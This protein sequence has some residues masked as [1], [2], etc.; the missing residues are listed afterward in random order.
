MD[1]FLEAFEMACE[2][3]RVDP[4][5]R[6]RGPVAF[7]EV[8]V[9]FT[10]GEWALLDPAQR[11]LYRDVMQENY[12]NV[13]S[14]A[15]ALFILY[16]VSYSNVLFSDLTLCISIRKEKAISLSSNMTYEGRLKELAMFSFEERVRENEE[17]NPRQ[18]DAE[19]VEAHGALLRRSKGNVSSP[20]ELGKAG[21]SYHRPE[22]EQGNHSEEKVDEPINYQGTH[23]DLKET[24]SQEKILREKRKNTCIECGKNFN[25]HSALI[26]HEI[27]HIKERAYEC[28]ECEKS[29]NHTSALIRHQRI[30]RG[31]RPYEYCECGK[32]F[33]HSSVLSTHQLIHTGER[34]YECSE[35][36]KSFIDIASLISHQKVHTGE[37]PYE[38]CECAESFNHNSA[39]IRHQRIPTGERSYKCCKCG[40]SFTQSS[41]LTMH[42]RIH[43][44]LR[45][46]ECS[47]CR[48]SFTDIFLISHQKVHTGQRPYECLSVGKAS[49]RTQA[50]SIIT[51]S[52]KDI[53]SITTFSRAVSGFFFLN[54]FGSSQVVTVK[55]VCIICTL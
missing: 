37:K 48:K 9:Y 8:A 35:C 2:M 32:S 47:E 44:R 39:L 42:Q 54:S 5:D 4:A 38:C 26:Q 28:C 14:L 20:S 34:P 29:F 40:K 19:L 13:T 49:L 52:I 10:K 41:N 53:N 16:C 25:Y 11:A 6:L 46:Y 33:T 24:T 55:A 27:I 7:E 43:T 1:D 23:K 51:E 45:P 22:R 31:E 30:H 36:G 17:Q 50:F 21:E 15:R 3:H 18:E 12:E